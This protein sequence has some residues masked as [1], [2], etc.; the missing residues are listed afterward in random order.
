MGQRHLGV[1]D[2]HRPAVRVRMIIVANARRAG[3]AGSDGGAVQ[4][5]VSSIDHHRP[6]KRRATPTRKSGAVGDG[7]VGQRRAGFPRIHRAAVGS[8]IPRRV[9]DAC[10]DGAVVQRQSASIDLHGST[11][12]VSPSGGG[13]AVG[14]GREGHRRAGICSV[15]RPPL[16]AATPRRDRDA[17]GDGGA[18]HR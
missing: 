13:V 1:L 17:F 18:V 14:D 7:R 8:A 4:H 9:G 11:K 6:T 12:R 3:D 5:H 15:H 16:R 2:E 10:S